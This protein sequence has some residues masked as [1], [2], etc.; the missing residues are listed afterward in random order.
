VEVTLASFYARLLACCLN[1][2]QSIIL[3]AIAQALLGRH[4][5]INIIL[6]H[7]TAG[8]TLDPSFHLQLKKGQAE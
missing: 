2:L 4:F 3:K 6:L 1:Y 5:A 7:Q 8:R